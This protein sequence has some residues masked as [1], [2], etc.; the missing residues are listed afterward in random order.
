MS[1]QPQTQ[2]LKQANMTLFHFTSLAKP[3][4]ASATD[5]LYV[6]YVRGRF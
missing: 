2:R 3:H 5:V 4:L 6:Q 1:K